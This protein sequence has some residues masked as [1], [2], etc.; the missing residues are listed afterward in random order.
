MQPSR[1]AVGLG[2]AISA[3]ALILL[4]PRFEYLTPYSGLIVR[5]YWLPVTLYSVA[6]LFTLMVLLG[7]L[8]RRLGLVDIGKTVDLVDRSIRRGEGDPDLSR[9]LQDEERGKYPE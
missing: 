9:R 3:V 5:Q 4:L 2:A 7:A 1:V 8:A 6:A